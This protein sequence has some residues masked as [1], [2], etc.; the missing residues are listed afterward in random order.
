MKC[1]LLT[2]GSNTIT[3]EEFPCEAQFVNPQVSLLMCKPTQC[4]IDEILK[5]SNKLKRI[6]HKNNVKLPTISKEVCTN[7]DFEGEG[8]FCAGHRYA[9]LLKPVHGID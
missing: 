7:E 6:P 1:E 8:D 3:F 9:M 5:R 2:F 4:F